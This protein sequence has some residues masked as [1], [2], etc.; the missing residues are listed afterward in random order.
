VVFGRTNV[1]LRV[2]LDQ[3]KILRGILPVCS[4]CKRVRT[5]TN[6][7]AEMETYIREH[8]EAN[9]SHTVCPDCLR[10]YYPDLYDRQM[11]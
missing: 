1:K 5:E 8:S 3:I 11:L 4:Y 2:S 6:K 10:K 9:F 7:W